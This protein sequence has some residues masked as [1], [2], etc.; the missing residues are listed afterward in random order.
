MPQISQDPVSMP[1][2]ILRSLRKSLQKINPDKVF[3]NGRNIYAYT[4]TDPSGATIS[5]K[6]GDGITTYQNLLELLGN[7]NAILNQFA[8]A[9]TA[10]YW[11]SGTAQVDTA[12]ILP[13]QVARLADLILPDSIISGLALSISGGNTN[14]IIQPGAWRLSNIV[15]SAPSVTT[16]PIDAQDATLSRFDTLYAKNDNTIHVASGT[17]SATPVEPAIPGGTIRIGVVSITPTSVTT[18]VAPITNYVDATT[19]QTAHGSKTWFDSASFQNTAIFDN[20]V[21]GFSAIFNATTGSA[22]EFNGFVQFNSTMDLG[23]NQ[24]QFTNTNFPGA[25]QPGFLF[26]KDNTHQYQLIFNT[27]TSTFGH[28]L[29]NSAF[30]RFLDTDDLA[31]I[32]TSTGVNGLN[33]TTSIGLGGTLANNTTIN[34]VGHSL[35]FISDTGSAGTQKTGSY[36][37][38]QTGFSLNVYDATL[39]GLFPPDSALGAGIGVTPGNIILATEI[40]TGQPIAFIINASGSSTFLF[41]DN[42]NF[43]GAAYAADYSTSGSSNP[44][45]I[46]DI[47]FITANFSAIGSSGTVTTI[48]GVNTNGFTWS[49]ANPTTTPALTLTLQ[50]AT[51]SQSGQL[52]ST[53]WNTFNGKQAALSGTGFVKSTG[54]TISYDTNTYLT[55]A[56]AASTYLPLLGGILTGPLTLS[57]DPTAAL[58]PATKN[59]VDNLITGITWKQEVRAATTANI[60]LSGTQTVDGVALIAGDRI[61]VKN[62]TTATGNGIYLVASGGWTRSL[63]ADT[64]SEIGS[65]TVLV[66]NGTVNKDTQWTCTNSTDPVI[67]TDNIT[68]GQISGAGTYTNGTGI[69]LASNVFSF[70]T[71]FGDGRYVTPA[72]SYTLSNKDLTSGT[73]TFPTFNQNTTGSAAKWTTA[74]LL[75]GNSVD[76]STNVAFANKFIVQGTTDAGLTGAQFL[77]A[78]GTGLVKNTTTTG[79]LSIATDGTDYLSNTTGDVRYVQSA[80]L[81]NLSATDSTLTFSGNYNTTVARTI[82]INL[83]NAN[84]WLANQTVTVSSGAQ[85]TLVNNGSNQATFTVNS[86]GNLTV[87]PSGGNFTVPI[88]TNTT[89]AANLYTPSSGGITHVTTS[90]FLFPSVSG[91]GIRTGVYGSVSTTLTASDSYSGFSV[92]KSP[93]TAAATGTH[94]WIT[95]ASILTLGAITNATPVTIT[96]TATLFVGAAS[97]GGTN[98]YTAYFDTGNVNVQNLTASQAAFT[99]A[100]KNLVSNAIT[101]TGNVVMST[102]PTL[103]TP[104]LGV[105]TATSINGNMFTTGTYTLTGAAGKTLTFNNS[106]TLAGTDAQTYTFPTTSATIARTDAGQTFSGTQTFNSG[107]NNIFISGNNIVVSQTT[108]A[109]IVKGLM[110]QNTTAASSGT[111]NQWS[112]SNQW[113]GSTWNT[114]GT[115]ASNTISFENHTE[116]ISSITP[117]GLLTWSGYIGVSTTPTYIKL[118]TLSTNALLTIGVTGTT[119]GSFALAGNTSGLV[120]I[121]PQAAAGTYNYNLP[122]TAGLLGQAQIS[123]GGGSSPMTWAYATG[124]VAIAD[125]TAQTAAVSSVATFT[126]GASTGTFR[127]GAYLNITA[128]TLDVIQVSVTYTDENNTSQTALFFGMGTTTAGLSAIGNSNFGVMDLRCK[129]ATAITVK[130]TLTTGTGTITYDVGATIQQLR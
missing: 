94:A 119:L 54:G 38:G 78:L 100:N 128:V 37:F 101:G 49:I 98:N 111:P 104:A 40:S 10:S 47:G 53:D 103:V 123:A 58:Q 99:D 88:I 112:L 44:R 86:S 87:A 89:L 39:S 93:V 46:P 34:G 32:G 17:L 129:N 120:S 20:R 75:A 61:L 105:A 121:L 15:Y 59:Y 9:Q 95:N 84:N 79:I 76:G 68:F 125:L 116:G 74:R 41:E 8:S 124:V 107:G 126:V 23:G 48:S 118:M 43:S 45:W 35:N 127:I 3:E 92:G 96:N 82:G 1:Q 14:V 109:A 110:L 33:G 130:T 91:I 83:S 90:G 71:T 69:L 115:P 16:L 19:N 25:A 21:N 51:T 102:S 73:N 72:G 106:I 55:T 27:A 52:T 113:L 64:G 6:L 13:N 114:S 5:H 18:I 7:T 42:F 11:I 22:A 62:Q 66:R 80:N 122:T 108:N 31:G 26:Y 57:A 97:S 81:L 117:S 67:G 30:K 29:N 63:D 65:A 70:D 60:T 56:S 24:P 28:E 36:T 4:G 2:V 85:L 77:G 12:P 50:N